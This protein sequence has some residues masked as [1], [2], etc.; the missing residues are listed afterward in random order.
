MAGYTLGLYLL[1]LANGQFFQFT[2]VLIAQ[3]LRYWLLPVVVYLSAAATLFLF[4]PH[5][6]TS[7]SLPVPVMP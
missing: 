3:R 2:Q 1:L 5:K 6:T 7:A 4:L